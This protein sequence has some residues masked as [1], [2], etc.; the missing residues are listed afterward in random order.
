VSGGYVCRCPEAALPLAERAWRVMLRHC[1]Y[2]AFHGYHW[3][4]SAWSTV[5]CLS[6][7]ATWRT[8]APYVEC[9]G[10]WT[11]AEEEAAEDAA[12]ASRPYEPE[13]V[14]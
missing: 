14:Q 9:L 5:R 3:T 8:R 1:N 10:D 12:R 7:L 6:C 4:A 2:S 13:D 11:Q